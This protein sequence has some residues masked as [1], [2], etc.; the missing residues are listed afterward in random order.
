[1]ATSRSGKK[2]TRNGARSAVSHAPLVV[3]R[4]RRAARRSWNRH[5]SASAG[6]TQVESPKRASARAPPAAHTQAIPQTTRRASQ[7]GAPTRRARLSRRLERARNDGIT[8]RVGQTTWRETGTLRN[9]RKARARLA[10][11]PRFGTESLDREPSNSRVPH[12]MRTSPVLA[13]RPKA[14]S[15]D[16]RAESE[17][18]G[19]GVEFENSGI[20]FLHILPRHCES[21]RS[22]ERARSAPRT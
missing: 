17:L 16:R 12:E 1:M 20:T 7:R 10:T 22:P 13:S 2:T 3:R 14:C 4:L 9:A 6:A 8:S 5:R 21:G 18:P 15:F 11:A 19:Q